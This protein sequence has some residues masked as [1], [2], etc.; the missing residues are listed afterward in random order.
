[1]N[2]KE[3]LAKSLKKE[4][5]KLGLSLKDAAAKMGFPNYQT[6]GSIETGEREIKAWELVKLAKIY[7][8][9]IDYFL[10]AKESHEESRILWRSPEDSSEKSEIHIKFLSF[11][12]NYRHLQLILN[13]K[14]NSAQQPLYQIDKTRLLKGDAFQ[15][16]AGMANRI[17]SD[18]C[19]GSRPA[20]A[21]SK[22]LEEKAGIKVVFMPLPQNLSAASTKGDFGM[23]ILINSND[24]PWRQNFDLAHEFF[25]VLTWDLFSSDEVYRG[26]GPNKKNRIEQL[27]DVF[28]SALLLPE[29]EVR[30]EIH[31][32]RRG[33]IIDYLSL[34]EI[35]R[36][37]DVSIEALLWRFVNIGIMRKERVTKL[38]EEGDII[39]IDKSRRIKKQ[40]IREVPISPKYIS[41]AIR[42]YHLGRISKARF[43]EY[44][45]KEFSAV[46]SF[47]KHM[48]YSEDKDYSVEYRIT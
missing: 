26:T 27:A 11:C 21:L 12:R 42:A 13:E 14:E 39:N 20:C 31:L 25:H 7:G 35:A 41:L 43:A 8:R 44:I 40:I 45:D 23:A 5:E 30:K 24:A 34:T 2:L 3:I 1:M 22:I 47:L 6:L 15:Y 46:T 37:F 36:E 38:L 19:L 28:A 17:S 18:L 16:I 29:E 32:R 4:R 33:K 9:D 48:G 10:A